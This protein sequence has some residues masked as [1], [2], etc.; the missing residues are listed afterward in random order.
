MTVAVC[1]FKAGT[2]IAAGPAMLDYLR[3]MPQRNANVEIQGEA[4]C[5]KVF[6]WMFV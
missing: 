6:R 3:A 1:F 2:T 5:N 4:R